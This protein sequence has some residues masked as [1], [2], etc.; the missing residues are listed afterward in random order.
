MMPERVNADAFTRF[1]ALLPRKT[2]ELCR[3]CAGRKMSGKPEPSRIIEG[4][5]RPCST[6]T[7]KVKGA[8]K[9]EENRILRKLGSDHFFFRHF[10]TQNIEK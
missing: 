4:K 8:K 7:G 1:F 5:K 10:F 2:W 9:R 3:L 6:V